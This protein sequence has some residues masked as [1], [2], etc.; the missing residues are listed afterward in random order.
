MVASGGG[1]SWSVPKLSTQRFTSSMATNGPPASA[2]STALRMAS[3]CQAFS[4]MY[5]DSASPAML[6][7]LRPMFS[8]RASS[9]SLV[10]REV[11]TVMVTVLSLLLALVLICVQLNTTAGVLQGQHLSPPYSKAITGRLLLCAGA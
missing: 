8:A 2:C 5:E 11:R 9:C 3:T 1:S 6:L 4:L 7:V 10:S